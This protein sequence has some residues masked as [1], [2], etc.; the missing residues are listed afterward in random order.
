VGID[1]DKGRID[2]LSRGEPPVFE[3]GLAELLRS[4][5][6]AGHL[7]FTGDL[8]ALAD[9]DVIWACHDTPVDENDRADVASVVRSIEMTFDH[10]KSG[11][12]VL[13]SAQ[14]PAGSVASLQRSFDGWNTG[15]T[16]SFA[17]S[18]ENL[19]LGRAIE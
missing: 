12:I 13:V 15:R 7:T 19:R 4:A 18:P 9:A 14:L 1:A 6:D 11:A 3:P 16:V 2:A 5:M 10:L 17:C 8:T